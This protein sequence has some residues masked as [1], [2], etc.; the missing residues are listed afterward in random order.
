[1]NCR[2]PAYVLGGGINGLAVIRNLGRSGI[3][4]YSV[5][6][7][8]DATTYSKFCKKCYIIPKIE[9]DPEVLRSFFSDDNRLRAGGVLFPA[10]D[11]FSLHLSKLKQELEKN[12]VMPVSLY[13]TGK[14]L[15]DKR[16]FYHS[17]SEFDI[18]F[19]KTCFP[20]TLEE[21]RLISKDV[22][23]PVFIK[24]IDSQA[25]SL[26]FR[27]KCFT[28]NNADE[29]MKFYRFASENGFAMMLQEVIPG[30]AAKNVYGF[31]GYF[32]QNSKLKAGFAHL[33]LRGWPPVFGNT[34][35]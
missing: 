10:S 25:F 23:Y 6:E 13:E 15:V 26:K 16:E 22:E 5:V 4:V 18:P 30:L 14:K 32:D 24:P 9:K 7:K 28:A 31:E 20:E 33:R 3:T 34:L 17:L 35:S 12:Y 8:R 21:V 1:M 2:I 27:T 11:I 19:P 29:L